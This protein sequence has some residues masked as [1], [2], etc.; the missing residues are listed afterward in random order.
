M[1]PDEH[2]I[3]AECRAGNLGGF[4]TLYDR[5]VGDVFKFVYF[6][7]HHKETAEDLTSHIFIKALEHVQDFDDTKRP[8]NAWIFSIARNTVIDH[9]RS[10]KA[11]ANIDDIWD[12]ADDEDV[13]RDIQARMQMVKVQEYMNELT[14]EQRDIVILRVWQ[15]LPYKEIAEIVGK[16]EASCKMMF[17]RTVAKMR[18]D[19]LIAC[20]LLVS[21]INF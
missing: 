7:T 2:T 17:S 8:F 6:K 4:S 5:Y 13:A 16:S 20:L 15:D 10:N 21:G 19:I 12:L 18:A 3:L 14:S 11:H 9:Y 1:H